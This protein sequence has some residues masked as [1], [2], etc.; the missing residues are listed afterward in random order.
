VY[1]NELVKSDPRVPF[2]GVGESGYGR[3]LSAV[4]I[5]EF[6]NRKTVWIAD[7]PDTETP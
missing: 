6:L 1:V 2:G 7:E 5:R 3:E 4:G